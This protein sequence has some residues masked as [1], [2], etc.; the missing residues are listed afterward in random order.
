MSTSEKLAAEFGLRRSRTCWRGNCPR[1][2]CGGEDTFTLS[3]HPSA[4]GYLHAHCRACNQID[5]VKVDDPPLI[6]DKDGRMV[7]PPNPPRIWKR[8]FV[9]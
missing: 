2:A 8:K 5:S 4:L 7:P 1:P 9:T 6:K 3:F